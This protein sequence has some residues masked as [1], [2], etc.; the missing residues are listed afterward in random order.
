MKGLKWYEWLVAFAG[1]LVDAPR[2]VEI[3]LGL[4]GSAWAW[5]D[6]S[7]GVIHGL[8]TGAFGM[9][10]AAIIIMACAALM[11]NWSWALAGLLTATVV[12][13]VVATVSALVG[14]NGWAA[15]TCA[16]ISPTLAV[17]VLPVAAHSR[18]N[19][20]GVSL[21]NAPKTHTVF[22]GAVQVER[23]T[24]TPQMPALVDSEAIPDPVLAVDLPQPAL[25]AP[26][27]A[28][29]VPVSGLTLSDSGLR[30][31]LTANAQANSNEAA[32][33]FGVTPPRIR[34]MAAWKERAATNA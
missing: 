17:I 15:V 13:S 1:A 28:N 29:A 27:T 7:R 4:H 2:F 12:T 32:R 34:Q 23:V 8:T 21:Q 19:G 3:G 6:A 31:W 14:A 33:A 18:A 26:K 22:K 11:S 10:L 30:E 20:D 5:W 24:E 9:V 16:A 25:S